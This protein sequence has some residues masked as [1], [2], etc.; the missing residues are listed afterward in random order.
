MPIDVFVNVT[1]K[2]VNCGECGGT[3]AIDGRYHQQRSE[4]GGYWTCPYCKTSWGF[5]QHGSELARLK[6]KLEFQEAE[7]ERQR[8]RCR[9]SEAD[10]ERTQRRLSATQGVLTRTKNRVARGV[11]PCCNRSFQDLMRHMATKHPEY[12]EQ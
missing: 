2:T 5:D 1:L 11:C 8:S 12:S 3:Y 7:T 6:R 9:Q 10:H 4:K